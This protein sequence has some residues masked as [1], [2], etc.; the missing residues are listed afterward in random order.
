MVT[1]FPTYASPEE[2]GMQI[3]LEAERSF[4]DIFMRTGIEELQKFDESGVVTE[5]NVSKIKD[6]VVKWINDVW[7]GIKKAW[8]TVLKFIKDQATNVKEKIRKIA[9]G[10]EADLKKKADTLLKD[11][12]TYGKVHTWDGYADAVAGNG[13]IKAACVVFENKMEMVANAAK[14][15]KEDNEGDV[16]NYNRLVA[17]VAG[18]IED[19]VKAKLG[20]SD[21]SSSAV[22]AGVKKIIA[23][24]EKDLK[25]KDIIDNWADL[26]K[27]ATDFGDT[28]SK[29]KGNLNATKKKFDE[30]KK[31]VEKVARENK[32]DTVLA[33]AV[34]VVKKN[35][36]FLNSVSSAT[37]SAV[38]AR[39]IEASKIVLRVAVGI[40][41]KE[42]NEE[43]VK[44]ESASIVP[45]AFQTELASLFEI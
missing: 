39:S 27:L 35:A 17:G 42:K 37:V 9:N 6:A 15:V 21:S 1:T 7:E 3:A 13:P 33:G 23:G 4:N 8:E 24:E 40:A 16:T 26:Y 44:N 34:K 22:A 45:S 43:A 2:M 19:A 12:K 29:V 28:A 32:G 30:C 14:S 20:I 5:A 41:K 25:K 18:E 38:K 10:K 36:M 11:D 31:V